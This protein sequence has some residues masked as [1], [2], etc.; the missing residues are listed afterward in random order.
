[1]TF[2]QTILSHASQR[3]RNVTTYVLP[4]GEILRHPRPGGGYW[5][6]G[7][8]SGRGFCVR[9]PYVGTIDD[10]AKE[11]VKE[12]EP[13]VDNPCAIGVYQNTWIPEPQQFVYAQIVV[14]ETLNDNWDWRNWVPRHG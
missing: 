9:T 1:M 13:F 8:N 7:F 12:L 14:I 2:E 6:S 4:I 3:W 11:M 5:V 10:V